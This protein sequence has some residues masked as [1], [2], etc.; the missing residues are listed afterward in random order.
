MYVT[1]TNTVTGE[2]LALE[3]GATN[4]TRHDLPPNAYELKLYR[5]SI[6]TPVNV[7]VA[8]VEGSATL[9]TPAP[10]A[11]LDL[12]ATLCGDGKVTGVR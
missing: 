1:L 5:G 2:R 11:A 8:V 9:P 4:V 6:T 7:D 3:L 12:G 10:T